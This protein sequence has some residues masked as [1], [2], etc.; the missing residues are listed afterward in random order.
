MTLEEL[1]TKI[2]EKAGIP[3]AYRSF[4]I[5]KPPGI[6]FIVYYVVQRDD[7]H[8]D[9]TVF[10]KNS[11]I[12]VELYFVKKDLSLENKLESFFDEIGIVYNVYEEAIEEE[13]MMFRTYEFDLMED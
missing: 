12:N 6:P 1:R 9:D 8:A 11:A 4:E 3:V 2:M 10:V 13:K 5:D 7:E